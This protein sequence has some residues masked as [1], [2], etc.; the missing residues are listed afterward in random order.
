M[1]DQASMTVEKVLSDANLDEHVRQIG[2]LY[3]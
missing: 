1:F 2:S 3:K